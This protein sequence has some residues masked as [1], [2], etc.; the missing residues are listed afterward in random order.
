[1]TCRVSSLYVVEELHVDLVGEVLGLTH[2][3]L[4]VLASTVLG[5]GDIAALV[6]VLLCERGEERKKA[7]RLAK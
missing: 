1:M 7:S 4:E 3:S 5:G 6:V 2:E